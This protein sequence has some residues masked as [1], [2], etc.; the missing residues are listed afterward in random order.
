MDNARFSLR[1]GHTGRMVAKPKLILC[2][3]LVLSGGLPGCSTA[4]HSSAAA[5]A[6]GYG[7]NEISSHVFGIEGKVVCVQKTAIVLNSITVT[8]IKP[9][10]TALGWIPYEKPGEIIV[11]HF[12][13]SL[14]KLG[15]LQLATGNILKV[16]FGDGIE[17]KAPEYWR[18]NFSWL[19]VEKK[20]GFYNMK[21][22][23]VTSEPG[24]NL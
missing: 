7:L 3:A 12:D 20:G 16:A 14:S 18:S 9:L 13:E 11:I 4:D 23:L 2:L 10:P 8:L 5:G 24:D 17:K 22:E 19:Y 21:G 15:K 6:N 1:I